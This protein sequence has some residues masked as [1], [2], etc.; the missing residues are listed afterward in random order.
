MTV[1]VLS[2]TLTPIFY[3]CS[4]KPSNNFFKFFCWLKLR[5]PSF[6]INHFAN[7]LEYYHNALLSTQNA[8]NVVYFPDCFSHLVIFSFVSNLISFILIT[9]SYLSNFSYIFASFL[10]F[11]SCKFVYR[12]TN[13][14]SEI[15][16]KSLWIDN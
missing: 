15:S 14:M 4:V 11:N 7:L 6:T 3:L 12:K 8:E 13:L 16:W 2:L 9:K 5:T 10:S 1:I